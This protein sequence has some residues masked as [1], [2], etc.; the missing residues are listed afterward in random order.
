M[1]APASSRKI[2]EKTIENGVL[3]WLKLQGIRHRKMNGLGNRSWPDQMILIPGGKP[4]FI[5]FKRPGNDLSPL[6]ADTINY[7]LSVGYDVEV[8]TDR[9]RAI[10]AIEERLCK[11]DARRTDRRKG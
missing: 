4:F 7:L 11:A 10:S 2:L 1:A 5:E 3:R 8:H 9:A 6:Q